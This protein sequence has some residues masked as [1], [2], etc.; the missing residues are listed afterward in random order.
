VN[1]LLRQ[2][3]GEKASGTGEISGTLPV[4]IGADGSIVIANGALQAEKPG[5]IV[6]PPDVIP[7]DNENVA[8]ARDVMKN[9]H[10]NVLSVRVD[11]DKNDRISV[12]MNVEGNNP[13]VYGGKAVKLN[14][15]LTGDVLDFIRQ[16]VLA[17]TNPEKLLEQ[18]Q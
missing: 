16:N 3:T 9:L 7:G 18:G 8:L 12:L 5:M 15:H 11:N 10:Y 6:L 4:T 14:V 13:D 2:L 17:L 1:D